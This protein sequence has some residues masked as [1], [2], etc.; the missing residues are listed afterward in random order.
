VARPLFSYIFGQEKRVWNSSQVPLV[1]TLPAGTGSVDKGIMMPFYLVA[2]GAYY[3]KCIIII[4]SIPLGQSK[5]ILK[6]QWN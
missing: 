1:L 6:L 5:W 3:N 2:T 4:V